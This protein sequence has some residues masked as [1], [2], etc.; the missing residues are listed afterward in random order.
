[1]YRFSL[2]NIYWMPLC[3][4]LPNSISVHVCE[5][6]FLWTRHEVHVLADWQFLFGVSIWNFYFAFFFPLSCLN[7]DFFWE[8]PSACAWFCQ[9]LK[10]IINKLLF[11][12]LK[13][14]LVY[15][16]ANHQDSSS[17]IHRQLRPKFM[18]PFIVISVCP[19]LPTCAF[20]NTSFSEA[21][22]ICCYLLSVALE[23]NFAQKHELQD[24]FGFFWKL[25]YTL[26]LNLYSYRE[27]CF[28]VAHWKSAL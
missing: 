23:N 5:F 19:L 25:Y 3:F 6:V 27:Y 20:P 15:F 26:G 2:D 24:L 22:Y 9:F 16:F 21:A 28:P 14:M 13:L 18:P 11:I 10:L 7:D 1:M 8:S 12:I 4:V 17:E